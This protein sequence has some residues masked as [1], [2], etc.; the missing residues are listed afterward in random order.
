MKLTAEQIRHV[1]SFARIE[2]SDEDIEEL[3][4]E[5]NDILDYIKQLDD[6]DDTNLKQI[7]QITGLT[8]VMQPDKV[9]PFI[10]TDKL[11][12]SSPQPIKKNMIEVKKTI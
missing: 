11:L 8:D 9:V 5:L 3:L 10:D 2:F 6:I 12:S 7:D 4:P 1:A